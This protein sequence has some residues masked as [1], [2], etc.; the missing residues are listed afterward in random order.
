MQ[1]QQGE[2]F[3]YELR[4]YLLEKWGR[5]CAYCAASN[6]PLEIEHIVARKKGGSDR[7]A[8]LTLA[9]KPC[10]QA[11]GT[12][13]I[14]TFLAHDPKRLAKILAQAKAPLKDAAAINSIRYAIGSKLKEFGLPVS[15]WS[16]GRTK[17][18]RIKQGYRK[19]HWL[20]AVCVGETGQKVHVNGALAPLIITAVGRGSRQMCRVDRFGFPR[21]GAKSQKVVKGFKTGDMVKA[22]VTKGKKI[23]SYIGRVAVRKSGSFNIKTKGATV[24]GISWKYCSLLQGLV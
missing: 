1:Y 12:S 19:T 10:N 16:G 24:Q 14:K 13:D 7:A 2:L 15:F 8:N 22:M 18:N 21:T 5:K 17:H 9:C 11:K 23:G 3:G 20:D 6:V 4:E